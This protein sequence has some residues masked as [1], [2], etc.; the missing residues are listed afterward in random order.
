MKPNTNFVKLN[1]QEK[2]EKG[3]AGFAAQIPNIILLANALGPL[4]LSLIGGVKSFFSH[5]GEAKINKDS[6][7]KW[8]GSSPKAGSSAA[9][10]KDTKQPIYFIY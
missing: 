6:S 10:P 4:F 9:G 5:S 3:G 7:I 8:D 1:E 2:Y